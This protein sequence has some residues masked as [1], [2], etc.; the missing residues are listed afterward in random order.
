MATHES[1]LWPPRYDVFGVGISAATYNTARDAVFAAAA[2]GRPF[3]TT[4][5]AVHGLIE[6]TR[7]A[8]LRDALNQFDMVAPDGQPVRHALNLLYRTGL[9]DNCRGPVLMPLVCERAAKEAVPV[10]L[11]GS[12]QAVIDALCR[13]LTERYP[14]LIIAGAEPSLF[15]PL[16]AE[17]DRE[18]AERVNGSGARILL[19][20]LGC[21]LQERF[22]YAHRETFNTVQMCVGAAFDFQAGNKKMAPAWMTRHSLEWLYRLCQEPRRLFTRYFVTNSLFMLKLL[23]YALRLRKPAGRRE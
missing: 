21:P 22:A 17:E 1:A 23:P 18:L 4:H 15:R 14:G 5:L 10:Y 3:C 19:L 12:T 8:D 9:A 16:T 7:H 2:T 6:A 20:G 13:N 11:Y